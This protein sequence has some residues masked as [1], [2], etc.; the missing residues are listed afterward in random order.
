MF[1]ENLILRSRQSAQIVSTIACW[2]HRFFHEENFENMLNYTIACW[3]WTVW[4][5]DWAYWIFGPSVIIIILVFLWWTNLIYPVKIVFGFLVTSFCCVAAK[6]WNS[7]KYMWGNRS[8]I[9]NWLA[10]RANKVSVPDTNN[11]TAVTPVVK[12][13]VGTQPVGTQP[14]EQYRT[15][16]M[17]RVA[18]MRKS[19]TWMGNR[20]I[21]RS[22]NKSPELPQT[23]N[24]GVNPLRGQV[25]RRMAQPSVK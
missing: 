25:F 20:P 21:T 3:D 12:P 7:L 1:T 10:T 4:A 13:L 22:M 14:V 18:Q 9:V 19:D 11:G 6:T 24:A 23:Q 5:Y 15:S 2:L 17:I 16:A 8:G